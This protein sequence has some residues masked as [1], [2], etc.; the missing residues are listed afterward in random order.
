MISDLVLTEL[1]NSIE[2]AEIREVLSS[3][4][5]NNKLAA[6]K[7]SDSDVSEAKALKKKHGEVPLPDLVH[8]CFAVGNKAE[9]LVTRDAHYSALP[10]DKIKIRK[11]E[12]I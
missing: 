4:K 12:E 11:P 9:V 8:Y 7:V 10:Q 1:R 3:L 6:G 2:D 5:E